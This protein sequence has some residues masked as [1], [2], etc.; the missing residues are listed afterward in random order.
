LY[1]GVVVLKEKHVAPFMHCS[2]YPEFSTECLIERVNRC[3][4]SEKRGEVPGICN[5][6]S[7]ERRLAPATLSG[8]AGVGR[9]LTFGWRVD[10]ISF[11]RVGELR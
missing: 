6:V 11:P 10:L 7:E 1:V 5:L 8:L 2:F 9:T 3:P 4:I